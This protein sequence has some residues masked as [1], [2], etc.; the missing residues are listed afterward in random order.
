MNGLIKVTQSQNGKVA[1]TSCMRLSRYKQLFLSFIFIAALCFISS[2]WAALPEPLGPFKVGFQQVVMINTALDTNQINKP[3]EPNGRRVVV[4]L[5]YPLDINVAKKGKAVVYKFDYAGDVNPSGS[6]PYTTA[7]ALD[8]N[9]TFSS[10]FGALVDR[11][12]ILPADSSTANCTVKNCTD[13]SIVGLPVS[14][15]GPFPLVIVMHGGQG[16]GIQFSSLGEYLASFGYIVASPTVMGFRGADFAAGPCA[17]GQQRPCLGTSSNARAFDL[18]FVITQ[19]LDKSNNKSDLFYRAINGN[20]IGAWGYSAGATA[21]QQAVAGTTAGTPVPQDARIKAFIAGG[22]GALNTTTTLASNVTVPSLWITGTADET[23]T[24]ALSASYNLVSTSNS[25][26]LLTIKGMPHIGTHVTTCS[27]FQ[28]ILDLQNNGNIT[29]S[30]ITL[31]SLYFTFDGAQ[32][33]GLQTFCPP[34]QF[35]APA[36]FAA[37]S[38]LGY[39]SLLL[40]ESQLPGRI[41]LA[42]MYEPST[43]ASTSE[44]IVDIM[45]LAFFEAHLKNNFLAGKLLIPGVANLLDS[46]ISMQ[47]CFK[48]GKSS[49]CKP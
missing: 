39:S 24:A 32:F 31:Y 9:L 15:F 10:Y 8:G 5:Y 25:K 13:G 21:V 1:Q 6:L 14:K 23:R 27:R 20:K 49:V 3:G 36:N 11:A 12:S 22:V 48:I 26:Y 30:D 45:T 47:A 17:A 29:P 38:A 43:L 46:H 37:L 41:N 18:S 33:G 4:S 34:S 44:P 35:Y 40:P 42:G 7:Q 16:S 2:T 28:R 19:M